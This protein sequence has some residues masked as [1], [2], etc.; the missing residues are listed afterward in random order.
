M[1][2]VRNRQEITSEERDRDAEAQSF[3]AVVW[4]RRPISYAGRQAD[5]LFAD[6]GRLATAKLIGT[7][8][9]FVSQLRVDSVF[10]ENVQASLVV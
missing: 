7:D 2:F 6:G 1:A 4:G 9:S 5:W 8:Q 3:R 10:S